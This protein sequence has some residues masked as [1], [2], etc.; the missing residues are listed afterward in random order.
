MNDT[1]RMDWLA[2]DDTRLE[3]VR[4]RM[5]NENELIREAIDALASLDEPKKIQVEVSGGKIVTA[6]IVNEGWLS[7]LKTTK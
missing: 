4:F 3:D 7:D 5:A 6:E 1:E 2:A